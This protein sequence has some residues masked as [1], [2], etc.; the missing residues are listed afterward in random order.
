[1]QDSRACLAETLA[2]LSAIDPASVDEG[3]DAP[4]TLTLLNDLIFDMTRD[5]YIWD[6]A[7]LQ[8]HFHLI[9]AYAI[10]HHH[11]VELSK[12]DYMPH[13]FAYVRQVPDRQG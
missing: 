4:I 12:A 3:G 8:F 1:M 2:A 5:Q 10:L 6:R 11:G 7:L 13:M 9:T